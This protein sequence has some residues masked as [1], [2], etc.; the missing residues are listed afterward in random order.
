MKRKTNLALDNGFGGIMMWEAG[1]D[2][3][4]VNSMTAVIYTE[5]EKSNVIETKS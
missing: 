5:L 4:D 3:S 1:H 2:T